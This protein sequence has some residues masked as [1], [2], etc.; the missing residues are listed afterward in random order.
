VSLLFSR[1]VSRNAVKK[2]TCCDNFT[3][4]YQDW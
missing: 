2:C 4:S 1:G 3:Y